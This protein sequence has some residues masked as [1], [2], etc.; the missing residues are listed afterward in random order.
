MMS[1]EYF[2]DRENGPRPRDS[3]QIS[4][5]VWVAVVSM[6]ENGLE[7]A[8]FG[9]SYP[10][11]CPD[12]EYYGRPYTCNG[13]RFND[14]LH[15]HIPEL[16]RGELRSIKMPET[17]VIMDV[18]EFCHRC[19]AKPI[20]GFYHRHCDHYHLS[21]DKEA[22]Q[23]EFR[24]AINALFER[25]RLIFELNDDGKVM[26]RGAPVIGPAIAKAQFDTG[27]AQ[28]NEYLEDARRKYFDPDEKVRRAGLEDLWKAWEHLK[29]IRLP[30]KNKKATS[31]G[32]M[33]DAVTT[34]PLFREVVEVDAKALTGIGND[35][36]IRHTETYTV[37]LGSQEQADY[38]FHRLFAMIWLIL[39]S[40]DGCG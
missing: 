5:A 36:K 8:S 35:F 1:P 15:A 6:V 18:I 23:G 13:V 2:S 40:T 9:E 28:L 22:G 31:T 7:K 4:E 34:E 30:Y 19:V 3:E 38:F 25:N 14:D 24:A 33:L 27:D 21:F 37:P 29:T 26:R 10:Q 11:S 39:E 32:L 16:P 20:R 17:N 12:P